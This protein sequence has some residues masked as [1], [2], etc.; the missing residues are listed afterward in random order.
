M[1]LIVIGRVLEL[2]DAHL[3]TLAKKRPDKTDTVKKLVS[4]HGSMW[5][6]YGENQ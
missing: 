6:F 2:Q 3:A 5:A 4:V 1:S